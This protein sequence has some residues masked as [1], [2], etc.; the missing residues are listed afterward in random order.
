MIHEGSTVFELDQDYRKLTSTSSTDPRLLHLSVERSMDTSPVLD[1]FY[2][3]YDGSTVF[4][5]ET[6]EN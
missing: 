3:I 5:L 2:A 6:A 4:E 1:T